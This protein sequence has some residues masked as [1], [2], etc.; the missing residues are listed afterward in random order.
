SENFSDKESPVDLPEAMPRCLRSSF[1]PF[2]SGSHPAWR[3]PSPGP[4]PIRR[5]PGAKRRR[6]ARAS[7]IGSIALSRPAIVQIRVTA[8]DAKGTPAQ[9]LGSRGSGFIIDPH[10]YVLTAQHVI[11]K[12]KDVEIRLAD[13]Q[14][15]GA[16]IV[17]ADP[18][19]DVAILKIHGERL[20]PILSLSDS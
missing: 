15:L 4:L 20:L 1:L 5:F 7:L 16:Q 6:A 18:Q 3:G 11:D 14:R 17:A 9:P 10:G 12:A 2:V 8:Q 13:G 19:I